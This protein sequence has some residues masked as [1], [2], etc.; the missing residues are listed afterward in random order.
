MVQQ[1]YMHN[2]TCFLKSS[3]MEVGALKRINTE[4]LLNFFFTLSLNSPIFPNT[5]LGVGPGTFSSLNT[6]YV[7][8]RYLHNLGKEK[9]IH[10]MARNVLESYVCKENKFV[11]IFFL[12]LFLFSLL[13]G[14]KNKHK[15]KKNLTNI[16]THRRCKPGS[17]KP[18][19]RSG[20]QEELRPSSCFDFCPSF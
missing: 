7:F 9:K 17:T 19:Q 11:D 8:F 12:K 6:E 16:I 18:D 4:K 2:S 10:L 14:R 15:A 5:H 20:R 3:L 1:I 13:I